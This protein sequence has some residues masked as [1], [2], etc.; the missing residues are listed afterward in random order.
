MGKVVKTV[1][2]VVGIAAAFVFLGPSTAIFLAAGMVAKSIL[3]RPK[4]G[5]GVSQRLAMDPSASRFLMVGETAAPSQMLYWGTTGSDNKTL[6]IVLVHAC[7]E[8]HAF[9]GLYINNSLVSF[10][11]INATGDWAGCLSVEYKTGT[12]SQ[13]A[14]TTVIPATYWTAAHKGAGLALAH[15]KWTYNK[16]KLAAGLPQNISQRVKGLKVYDPRR[17]S[18]V[19]GSGTMR[20]TDQTTWAYNAGGVD[21]GRNPAL[22][23]LTYRLGIK[24]NGQQYAG[25]FDDPANIDFSSY[26]TAANICEEVVGPRLRYVCDGVLYLTDSHDENTGRI[27]ATCGGRIIDNGG[28]ISILV[29][30]NDTAVVALALG[31]DDLVG[32]IS[33]APL[34][35]IDSRRNTVRGQYIDPTA[36]YQAKD[37]AEIAPAGLKTEDQNIELV[38]TVG[39]DMVGSPGQART[40]ASIALYESRRGVAEA[41]F[42]LVALNVKVGEIVTLTHARFA[43]SAKKFRVERWQLTMEARVRLTLREVFSSDYTAYTDASDA[44][45]SLPLV[46]AYGF[47]ADYETGADV[48]ANAVPS[49]DVPA[50]SSFAADYDGT[51]K[52]WQFPRSLA[53]KRFR[54]AVDVTTTTAWSITATGCTASIGAATGVISI[55]AVTTSGKIAVTSVRDGVTLVSEIIVDV[56]KDLPPSGGSGGGTTASDPTIANVVSAS[57]GTTHAGVL[58]VKPGS[59]GTVTLS[60]PLDFTVDAASPAGSF[61]LYGKWLWRIVG[62]SW[63]DVAAEVQSGLSCDIV[64]DAE[65]GFYDLLQSGS[66]SV[67]TSKTGLTAGTDYEFQLQLRNPTTPAGAQTTRTRYVTGTATATG[68]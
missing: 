26:I 27:L 58:T 35:S 56:A 45:P 52:T 36:N 9:G 39:F 20:Y 49:T 32:P 63:A 51:V 16:D 60:A 19:G 42:S 11:G 21:I 31:D 25:R 59:G 54:G 4:F 24:Q 66:I 8:I 22:I 68:S 29:A 53:A 43:W 30:S 50:K 44:V 41:E 3:P 10:S 23:E 61:H 62:G 48:T 37:Y 2:K 47:E 15:H 7:H 38:D 64:Y 28:L 55:T 17:D 34:P 1:A 57:Y 46:T 12:D 6:S 33:W 14:F 5:G 40:L 13:T 65:G 18:T 67:N